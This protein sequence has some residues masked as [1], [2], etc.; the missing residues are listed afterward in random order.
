M[1]R[2]A[3]VNFV[4]TLI[5]YF[6]AQRL[7]NSVREIARNEALLKEADRIQSSFVDEISHEM[8]TPLTAISGFTEILLKDVTPGSD[9]QKLLDKIFVN[10]KHLTFQVDTLIDSAHVR[11]GK[12]SANLAP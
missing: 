4:I 5:S 11:S 7:G 1:Y 8:R 6:V 12:I 3:A 10:A 2:I 9:Q